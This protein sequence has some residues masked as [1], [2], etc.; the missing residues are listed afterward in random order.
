MW[1][2]CNGSFATKAVV[3]FS[4][5]LGALQGDAVMCQLDWAARKGEDMY[6]DSMQSPT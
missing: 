3:A 2:S 6:G 1:A 5:S 4:H